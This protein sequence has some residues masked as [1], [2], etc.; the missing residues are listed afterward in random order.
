MRTKKAIKKLLVG[1][2]PF[3]LALGAI[4]ALRRELQDHK[5]AQLSALTMQKIAV[6]IQ[7]LGFDKSAK[8]LFDKLGLPVEGL[9]QDITE[10]KKQF[11][12]DTITETWEK[13]YNQNETFKKEQKIKRRAETLARIA[14]RNRQEAEARRKN[15]E[16]GSDT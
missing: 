9:Y 3:S 8:K 4:L 12:V 10:E 14:E 11:F 5:H 13:G 7:L 16:S 2:K 6:K 1:T 15:K